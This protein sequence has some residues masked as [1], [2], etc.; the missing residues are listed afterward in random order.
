MWVFPSK[1][2]CSVRFGTTLIFLSFINCK[3][4]IITFLESIFASTPNPVI[5]RKFSIY[6]NVK[7]FSFAYFIIAWPRGCSELNSAEVVIWSKESYLISLIV[8]ISVTSG[9]PWVIVPVLSNI[10][11]FIL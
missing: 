5:D 6:L 4:S 11:G 2:N 7:D 1:A 10:K 9:F 3:L 8:I